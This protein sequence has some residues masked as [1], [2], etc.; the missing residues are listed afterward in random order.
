[1]IEEKRK[2]L[3]PVLNE[4]KATERQIV[5]VNNPKLSPEIPRPKLNTGE[6]QRKLEVQEG[7]DR[8][9]KLG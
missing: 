6:T 9:R 5:H 8:S 4:S 7:K 3:G 2:Q 1:M